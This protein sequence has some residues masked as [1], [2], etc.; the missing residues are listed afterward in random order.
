[1]INLLTF[2]DFFPNDFQLQRSVDESDSTTTKT[3][4]KCQENTPCGW[5]VYTPFTR[6]IDYFMKNT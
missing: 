5:A 1:M 6:K 3:E 2:A 4:E